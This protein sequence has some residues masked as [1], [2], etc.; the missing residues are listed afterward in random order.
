ESSYKRLTFDELTF[1]SGVIIVATLVLWKHLTGR[2]MFIKRGLNSVA[3]GITYFKA[4]KQPE[5]VQCFNKALDI[6]KKNVEA[7]VARGALYANNES[8]TRAIDDF[9]A[10]LKINSVHA[11]ARKYLHDTL[12]AYGKSNEDIEKY[13]E[14]EELYTK[15]MSLDQASVDAREALRFLHYRRVCYC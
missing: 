9:E 14:A 10:A 5:A 13:Q 8:F 7:L 15:A 6:D 4:G 1:Y 11:N 12:L 2:N 3:Q